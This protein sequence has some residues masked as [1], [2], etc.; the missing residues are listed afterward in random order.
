M[1]TMKVMCALAVCSLAVTA[2][3]H[4][5]QQNVMVTQD[6]HGRTRVAYL[7]QQSSESVALFA[8]GRS[9]SRASRDTSREL[10]TQIVNN[11][12]GQQMILYT[13]GE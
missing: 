3:A 13:A 5:D 6:A 12:H 10:K 4:D 7:P 11:P 2:F 9:I 1:K 8:H